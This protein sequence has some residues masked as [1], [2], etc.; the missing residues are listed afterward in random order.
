MVIAAIELITCILHGKR[1]LSLETAKFAV[2]LSPATYG[3]GAGTGWSS[4]K[5]AR[6]K[7]YWFNSEHGRNLSDRLVSMHAFVFT[8]SRPHELRTSRQSV[9][10]VKS[11]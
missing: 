8:S 3:S 6:R 11:Q 7:H 9:S 4:Q 10:P 2:S 1:I 5:P